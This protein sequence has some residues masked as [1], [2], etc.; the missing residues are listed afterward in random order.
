MTELIP[1]IL[2]SLNW[3][4]SDVL[5]PKH[6]SCSAITAENFIK[7]LLTTDTVKEAAINLDIGYQ[8]L[9]RLIAKVLV[10]IFGKLNGG[11]QTWKLVILTNAKIKVCGK[12]YQYLDHSN[13]SKD[14]NTF[15]KLD[16]NCKVCKSLVN[17]RFYENNKET[18]HKSYIQTHLKEYA[19]R[20]AKRRAA[21]IQAT[22]G[23]ADL[24]KI[25][26]IYNK[27]QQLKRNTNH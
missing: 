23:W 10:P 15:D 6:G 24:E 8:T 3:A 13:F 22:V 20:N 4:G 17:A 16:R 26:E 21:K 11:N 9:N 19:A 25:K 7:A 1:K 18:Y 12:C 27:F 5:K 14:S 2:S